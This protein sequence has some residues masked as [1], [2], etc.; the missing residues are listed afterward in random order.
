M[1]SKE[2]LKIRMSKE[3]AIKTLPK[4]MPTKRCVI[5][6]KADYGENEGLEI[7]EDCRRCEKPVCARCVGRCCEKDISSLI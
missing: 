3:I 7:V 6:S 4:D 2:S 1:M 5:C